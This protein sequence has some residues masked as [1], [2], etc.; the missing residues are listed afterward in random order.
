MTTLDALLI[1]QRIEIRLLKMKHLLDV[2]DLKEKGEDTMAVSPAVAAI[3]TQF[4]TATD[5]IAARMQR[6]IDKI[7]AG[8]TLSADDLAAFQAEND[9]LTALGKD[10]ADPIPAGTV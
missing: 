6:Y 3:I 5:A 4:D 1:A 7:N 9:K 2:C 8:Q 10:P